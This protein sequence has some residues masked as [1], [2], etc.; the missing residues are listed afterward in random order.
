[1]YVIFGRITAAKV[2]IE[3]ETLEGQKEW[4]QMV[5]DD[6]I[7]NLKTAYLQLHAVEKTGSTSF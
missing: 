4:R 6:T 3:L 2:P 7:V 1:M 5:G